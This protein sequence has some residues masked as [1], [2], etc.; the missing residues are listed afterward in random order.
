MTEGG[1]IRVPL[2]HPRLQE[3][4]VIRKLPP[5]TLSNIEKLDDVV[6]TPC[7][8]CG[9]VN[10]FYDMLG[11]MSAWTVRFKM[12]LQEMT[13]VV[14]RLGWDDSLPDELVIKIKNLIIATLKMGPI[15][16]PRAC[17]PGKTVGSPIFITFWDGAFPARACSIYTRYALEDGGYT[18]PSSSPNSVSSRLTAP[19]SPRPR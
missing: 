7:L 9:M 18:P 10:S 13:L 19:V 12:I 6:F 8:L 15:K 17:N 5:I 16:F 3:E 1:Q 2:S 4:S 11:L 14:P